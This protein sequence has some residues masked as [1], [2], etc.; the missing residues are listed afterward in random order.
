MRHSTTRELLRATTGGNPERRRDST[1]TIYGVVLIVSTAVVVTLHGVDVTLSSAQRSAGLALGI[2]LVGAG[3]CLAAARA[4]GPVSVSPPVSRWLASSPLPRAEL[5]RGR[6]LLHTALVL[7]CGLVAGLLAG[8]T[9]RGDAAT[10]GVGVAAGGVMAVGSVALAAWTQVSERDA[11]TA[12]LSTGFLGGGLLVCGMA[13]LHPGVVPVA[14]AIGA[15]AC[16]AVLLSSSSL[17]G[18]WPRIGG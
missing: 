5:V 3:T 7:V 2:G 18:C 13:A 14:V 11:L 17:S 1:T 10:C 15:S 16:S 9:A 8:L 6:T 12:R 4:L